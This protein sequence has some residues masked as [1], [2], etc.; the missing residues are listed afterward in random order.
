MAFVAFPI[1]VSQMTFKHSWALVFFVMLFTLG[2]GT[3]FGFLENVVTVL[4]DSRLM[5]GW[6]RWK[7]AGV[8]CLV[9]YLSGL[10]FVTRAGDY[11][12]SLFDSYAGALGALYVCLNEC[13]GVMWLSP[14]AYDFLRAKTEELTGRTLP[15]VVR[16][17][18][19]YVCPLYMIIAMVMLAFNFDLT[20]NADR[21]EEPFPQWVLWLGWFIA[22]IPILAGVSTLLGDPPKLEHKAEESLSNIELVLSQGRVGTGRIRRLPVPRAEEAYEAY[23]RPQ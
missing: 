6:R 16:F 11:W 14:N 20:G 1:A 3:G 12:V 13:V 19:K 22:F 8:V 15:P 9:S 5:R 21:G 23:A 18:W 4:H 2:I 7:V 10:I 17:F